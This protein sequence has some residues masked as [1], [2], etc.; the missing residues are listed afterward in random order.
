MWVVYWM[1]ASN[2][3]DEVQYV[4][5]INQMLLFTF[6]TQLPQ[7]LKFY[8]WLMLFSGQQYCGVNIDWW[9]VLLW[10]YMAAPHHAPALGTPLTP[11]LLSR[12]LKVSA[13]K[14]KPT[15]GGQGHRLGGQREG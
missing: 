12:G 14:H 1:V 8:L 7:N 6:E 15:A 11:S 13:H 2:T 9:T 10:V 5:K 3:F 4:I